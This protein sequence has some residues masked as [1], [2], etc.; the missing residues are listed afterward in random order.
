M[1]TVEAVYQNGVFKPVG[2][3]AL[4]ENQR[5]QLRVEPIEPVRPEE[6]QEWLAALKR[7]HE[8]W[9]TTRPPLPDST[10]DIAED[11]RRDV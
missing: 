2:P 9:L 5:V 6:F 3:V 8:E 1:T 10:P 11:R 4:T 7:R